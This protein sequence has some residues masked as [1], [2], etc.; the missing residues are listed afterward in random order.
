MANCKSEL[1]SPSKNEGALQPALQ[2]PVDKAMP[3]F[4]GPIKSS[5]GPMQF[6]VG[7]IAG[8]GGDAEFAKR[9]GKFFEPLPDAV[10][11]TKAD[12]AAL[13]NSS[14]DLIFRLS[15]IG[16]SDLCTT[17]G[18]PRSHT[19][20]LLVDSIQTTGFETLG[21]PLVIWKNDRT[22][23][24]SAFWMSFVKGHTRGCTALCIAAIAMDHFE[25][26][27]AMID[28]GLG[29][30]RNSLR[31][32]RV[33]MN[34]SQDL[35]IIAFQNASLAYKGSIRQAHDIV[36]WL[37]KLTKLS[38]ATGSTADDIVAKWNAQAPEGGKIAGQ[39]KV[40]LN[41]LL[42][43]IDTASRTLLIEH[44]SKHGDKGA[45]TDDSWTNKKIL[46][47]YKPA[48]DH[49]LWKKW[50]TVT[51]AS[52]KLMLQSLI[53]KHELNQLG[54][55]KVGKK[56]MITASEQA[57]LVMGIA[58]SLM[59]TYGGLP[60]ADIQTS[61]IGAF[62][63]GD[64]NLL[65]ALDAAI[66]GKSPNFSPTDV[67]NVSAIVQN[68]QARGSRDGDSTHVEPQ[69]KRM[70]ISATEL[71][72]Q[73]YRLW[74]LRCEADIDTVRMWQDTVKSLEAQAYFK[75]SKYALLR[76]Q[77][78]VSAAMSLMDPSHA[79]YC[80]LLAVA[81]SPN[82]D[83][84][85]LGLLKTAKDELVR[86]YLLPSIQNIT[87]L[88]WLNWA[89]MSLF[90]NEV[91][92]SQSQLMIALLKS[93]SN[94][95]DVVGLMVQPTFTYHAGHL[96][97]QKNK[98]ATAIAQRGVNI[99]RTMCLVFE[100]AADQRTERP[101]IVSCSVCVCHAD[102]K[103]NV[104]VQN[105]M[106]QPVIYVGKQPKGNQM[107]M[108]EDVDETALP[109]CHMDDNFNR[110]GQ[111]ERHHQIGKIACSK[112][113]NAAGAS[114]SPENSASLL[115][116]L[117]VHVGDMLKAFVMNLA[118]PAMYVGLCESDASLQF[119]K[120]ELVQFVKTTLQSNPDYRIAGF[121]IP[122]EAMPESADDVVRAPNLTT[123]VWKDGKLAV[124]T[125]DEEKWK[126]HEEFGESFE[127]LQASM[128]SLVPLQNVK[129]EIDPGDTPNQDL[130]HG[131]DFID[132][133]EIHTEIAHDI[134][135]AATKSKQTKPLVLK[136]CVNN[137][138]Y[139]VNNDDKDVTIHNGDL[140]VGYGKGQWVQSPSTPKDES[141]AIVYTLNSSSDN[142][143]YNARVS[144]LFGIINDKRLTS[145]ADTVKVMYYDMV[146]KPSGDGSCGTFDLRPIRTLFYCLDPVDVKKENNAPLVEQ[147]VAGSLLSTEHWLTR[148][149]R[150][151]WIVRWFKSKG[152]Q[153][154]RPQITWTHADTCVPAG[155][156]LQLG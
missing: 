71:E 100:S 141:K 98:A 91:N 32:I 116:D 22:H 90:V 77:T 146:D 117:S 60:Q 139:I 10:Y 136:I 92:S 25:S 137:V 6:L 145:D 47:G 126:D 64:P 105:L 18:P 9:L 50:L 16:Y 14:G 94:G 11:N 84:E 27:E 120:H 87:M 130:V 48:R 151:H 99:D 63:A 109:Q 67:P 78:C 33:R 31:I 118:K 3:D 142:V 36:N 135:L 81:D 39:K 29:N 51:H 155:K 12:C 125:R 97:N 149:T 102:C 35:Q 106:K 144:T 103:R 37:Q 20:L 121:T 129:D 79:N 62:V 19:S 154:I 45:F 2:P 89:A 30:L 153:P 138:L 134:P 8:K 122:P 101:L 57:A 7:H 52:F 13:A 132:A 113:L 68:W 1:T 56:T 95:T 55:E 61:F 65:V 96:H 53:Y 38:S 46:P 28:A 152:L 17:K 34:P 107:L 75:R 23:D 73:E 150:L 148:F 115:V 108:I 156:A 4:T 119:V 21:D 72:Q 42:N 5:G 26:P 140:L 76:A 80:V 104:L 15:D 74:A 54:S 128:A 70:K 143:V 49:P 83:P 82:G 85:F 88:V 24:Q 127:Q 69:A 58:D 133:T 147:S 124:A 111:A 131:L 40:S 86:K 43:H 112:I 123:L 66:E 114:D 93:E 110:L 41:S 44:A 59:E